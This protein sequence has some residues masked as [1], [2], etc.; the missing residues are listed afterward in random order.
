M[1][2]SF[3]SISEVFQ[4]HCFFYAASPEVTKEHFPLIEDHAPTVFVIKEK[5][6]YKFTCNLPYYFILLYFRTNIL[7]FP[8]DSFSSSILNETLYQWVNEER[9]GTFPKVTRGNINQILQTKKYI[10]L[11]VVEENKLNE[12][13]ANQLEFRDMVESVIR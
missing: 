7:L 2:Q 12:I 9:F 4:P 1:Q 5:D 11:A 8:D 3:H 10:V 6:H 13:E